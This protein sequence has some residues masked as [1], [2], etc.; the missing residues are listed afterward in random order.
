MTHFA[1]ALH[2]A[3]NFIAGLKETL[4]GAAH[5][6]GVT[7]ERRAMIWGT[8]KTMSLVFPVCTGG[9][10]E[11]YGFRNRNLIRGKQ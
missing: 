8:G 3:D 7:A 6:H 11:F 2:E 9:T 1:H 5:T 10:A 4:R